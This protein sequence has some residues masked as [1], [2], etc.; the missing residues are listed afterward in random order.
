[1]LGRGG[2]IGLG[3]VGRNFPSIGTVGDNGLFGSGAAARISRDDGT[4][5]TKRVGKPS[6][7]L[8]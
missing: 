7:C 6:I 2:G 1:M 8:Q 4:G 5:S 3:V